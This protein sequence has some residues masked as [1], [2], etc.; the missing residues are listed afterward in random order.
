MTELVEKSPP[1][2]LSPLAQHSA[3]AATVEKLAEGEENLAEETFA[4][5]EVVA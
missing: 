3:S 2:E 1:A 4:E 5:V